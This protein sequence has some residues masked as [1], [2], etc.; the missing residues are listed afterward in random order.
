[1]RTSRIGGVL[2]ATGAAVGVVAVV[3]MVLGFEPARLPAALLNIA[4]YKLTLIG[5]AGLITA[6]AIVRRRGK[7][8]SASETRSVATPTHRD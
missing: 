1:M 7:R 3:G 5:A 4:A 8:E 2:L 6:G